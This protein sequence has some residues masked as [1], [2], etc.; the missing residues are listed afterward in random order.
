MTGEY[1]SGVPKNSGLLKSRS[2]REKAKTQEN[3][4]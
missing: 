4:F 2:R 3:R 1:S